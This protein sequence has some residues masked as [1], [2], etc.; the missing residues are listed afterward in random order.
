MA[1][2][3]NLPGRG[4]RLPHISWTFP[5]ALGAPPVKSYIP[6]I[7]TDTL[8]LSHQLYTLHPSVPRST[9]DQGLEGQFLQSDYP[10]VKTNKFK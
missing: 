5:R 2:P 1:L 3:L 8:R 9:V 10:Y 6:Y 4:R 7:Y